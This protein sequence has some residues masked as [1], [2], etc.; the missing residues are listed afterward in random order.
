MSLNNL[1][2]IKQ[3][4]FIIVGLFILISFES[5]NSKDDLAP[6]ITLLGNASE[7]S[8]LN[9]PYVDAGAKALDETDGDISNNIFVENTVDINYFGDYLV[10][11]TCV[12]KAG[13]EAIPVSRSVRIINNSYSYADI[14]S[15]METQV[16]GTDTCTY[17]V[18]FTASLEINNRMFFTSFACEPDITVFAEIDDTLIIIPFQTFEDSIRRISF[19]GSGFISENDSLFFIEYSRKIDTQDMTYWNATIVR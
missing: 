6:V 13:N 15:A 8:S 17:M 19:Q 9:K 14:Y 2:Y 1:K 18:N 12:D 4:A 5:C 7:I 11:Y 16:Y 10:T 3:V